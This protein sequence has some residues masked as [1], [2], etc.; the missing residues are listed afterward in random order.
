MNALRPRWPRPWAP[1]TCPKLPDSDAGPQEPVATG[2]DSDAGRPGAV[3][4]A[5]EPLPQMERDILKKATAFIAKE[6]E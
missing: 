6:S 1:P 5:Q 4:T 3:A 2:P